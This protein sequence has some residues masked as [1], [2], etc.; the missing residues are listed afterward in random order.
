VV[1]FGLGVASQDWKY[2][3]RGTPGLGL[4]SPRAVDG[5]S[6]SR[7]CGSC[8]VRSS[9]RLPIDP[10]ANQPHSS[11]GAAFGEF[12]SHGD[13]E[14]LVMNMNEPPFLLRNDHAGANNWIEL[15]LDES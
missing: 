7:H 14:I 11:R 1:I 12:D 9:Y 15:K 5:L 3:S 8:F 4:P 2:D 6:L 10:G 13:V